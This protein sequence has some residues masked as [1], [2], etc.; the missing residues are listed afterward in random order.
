VY[1]LF[2]SAGARATWCLLSSVRAYSRSSCRRT[3]S[4][5]SVAERQSTRATQRCSRILFDF[6]RVPGIVY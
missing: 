2:T 3:A 5:L 4:L 6:K 1:C